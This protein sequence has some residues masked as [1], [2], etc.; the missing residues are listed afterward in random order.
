MILVAI[1][2]NLPSSAHP[3]PLAVCEAAVRA[4]ETEGAGRVVARS[5]WYRTAPVPVSG[6]PWFVNGVVVLE[7]GLDPGGLLARLHG[8]E[9]AFGRTRTRRNEARVLDLDLVDYDGQV[10]EGADGPVLPHPRMQERAFV[11]HPLRDVAPAW[12]H[13]V[14]GLDV[15]ALISRLPPGQGIETHPGPAS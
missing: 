4:L 8:I 15:D 2:S 7:T 10:R 3:T 9:A 12:R 6:Q 1:G 14:L 5:R 11:L 13:P